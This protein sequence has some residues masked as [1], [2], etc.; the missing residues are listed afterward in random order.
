M[1]ITQSFSS[2]I[3]KCIRVWKVMR[4]PTK[5]EFMVVIKVSAAGTLI[6]GALGFLIAVIM[7]FV[8][9]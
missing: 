1:N 4:K 6:I 8:V 9:R 3:Q 7:K 2:L 5:E